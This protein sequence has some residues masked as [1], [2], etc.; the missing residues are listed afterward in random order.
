LVV[1][2]ASGGGHI[3]LLDQARR[4]IPRDDRA[5]V[6]VP[7]PRAETLRASGETVF[8]LPP[9]DQRNRDLRNI[10][11]SIG[12]ARALR[13]RIVLTSGAGVVLTFVAAS[14]ALGAKVVFAETMARVTSP[15]ATGRVVNRFADSR[16]VQW[17]D[18]APA[19]TNPH[20]CRPMLLPHVV[21]APST[22]RVGTFLSVGTHTQPFP[23]LLGMVEDA[24]ARGL[25]PRP[26]VAQLGVSKTESQEIEVRPWLDRAQFQ[27]EL[28]G[29][30]LVIGHCGAGFV[31]AA[32]SV[33]QRPMILPRLAT[34][35][36]HVD[37]HQLQLL[38]KLAELRLVVALDERITEAEISR[39]A[40]LASGRK[41]AA[42]APE[43]GAVLAAELRRLAA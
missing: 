11:R 10:R 27:R 36:E 21:P 41:V 20:V 32:I 12:L 37:D 5:W 7:G 17:P 42:G 29:A 15:S 43:V 4:L 25:L 13:P 38:H 35:H 9:F 24:V 39:T 16:L 3:E 31:G 6:T 34:H 23:R 14:R 33:G 2:A 18:L 30:E 19:Y 26:I 1:L 8:T 40:E 28:S 22:G